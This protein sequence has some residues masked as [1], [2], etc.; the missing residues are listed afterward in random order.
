MSA[1]IS[2][3]RIGFDPDALGKCGQIGS[4]PILNAGVWSSEDP[5]PLIL[6][7]S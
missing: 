2:M 1:A 4:S 6:L 7:R 3:R 5:A